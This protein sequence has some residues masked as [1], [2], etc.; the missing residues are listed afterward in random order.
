MKKE[1]FDK[2]VKSKELDAI[3]EDY[4]P[5]ADVPAEVKRYG[6]IYNNF[7]SNF[8]DKDASFFSTP[9][10]TELGGNHTDHNHGCVIAGS[11]QLD[12]LAV[13]TKTDDN[14]VELIS[15]GYPPVVVNLNKLEVIEDEKESTNSLVRGLAAAFKKQGLNIGGWKAVS[16]S[17]VPGGSGLSSSAA[18]EV[19]IGTIFNHFYNDGKISS[20][21]IAKMSQWAENVYFGKPCGLMDQVACAHGGIVTIDFADP[22][23]PII[24]SLD[25]SFR[26]AGYHL[27]VVDTGGSHA[28][29]TDE[30]AAVPG[31]MKAVAKLLGK[32][33]LRG[34]KYEDILKNAIKIREFCGDRAFLRAVHFINENQR[35]Q[36]KAKALEKNDLKGYFELVKESGDSSWKYLQNCM[37]GKDTEHQGITTALAITQ[38]F[39]G[40]EGASRVHGGGFAG[41]IQVYI[42]NDKVDDYTKLM[43]SV[44]GKDSV[45]ALAIR[46]KGTSKVL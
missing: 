26:D 21:E 8:G 24:N 6:E 31:E 5:K 9:G 1:D 33:V 20:V 45:T 35:A 3:L 12:T 29:L 22:S 43:E 2:M 30:Y 18:V 17:E 4:Y 19:L 34:L 44:F 13:A 38:E 10:R 25:Y 23:K 14:I 40:K 42:P 46:C 37:T 36:L 15:V 27:M 32:E 28:D 11:V 39:L 41:T 7:I 16:T